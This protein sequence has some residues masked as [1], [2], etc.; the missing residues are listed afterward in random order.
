MG[1]HDGDR[2]AGCKTANKTASSYIDA[3]C[4]AYLFYRAPRFD[5]H[6][7]EILKT[8]PKHYIVDLGFRSCL[9][10]YRIG[11]WGR[12]FE[13]AVY[14]QLLTQGWAVHVGKLYSKEVDF[15]AMRD[16]ERRYIQVADNLA[17]ES[18]R[19]RELAP[20]RA[21]QDAYPKMIVAREGMYEDDVDGIRILRARDFFLKG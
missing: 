12:L 2:R 17:T 1:A 7:K 13:N 14:L 5:L 20:L 10:G 18:T 19:E 11:D 21:I 16:G 15:V 4:E 8:N 6:G 9:A 3:L